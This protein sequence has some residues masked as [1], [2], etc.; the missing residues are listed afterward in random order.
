[1]PDRLRNVTFR[2]P[3]IAGQYKL[4]VPLMLLAL[5]FSGCSRPAAVPSHN[6]QDKNSG[7]KVIV[8]SFYPVYILTQNVCA[9]IPGIMVVNM[10]EPQTG[11]LHDYQLRPEDVK[12]LEKADVF[13]IN[14]A[15]AEAFMDKVIQQQPNLT[16]IEASHGI[17]LIEGA[18]NQGD[19]P[20][21]WVSPALYIKEIE[22]V[23][24]G[25]VQA[26]PAHATQYQS[27]GQAYIK[28][29]KTLQKGMHRELDALKHRNVVTFHEAFP[30]FAQEFKLN[31]VAIIEREPGSAPS[32]AELAQTIETVKKSGTRALFAEPQ[33]SVKA[34]QTIASETG[35]T[36]Y[37]LDP[38]VTG[39]D[40]P[41]AYIKIM[42]QNLRI[43]KEA[44]E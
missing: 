40:Q 8:T 42:T 29:I 39:P 20:H 38:G 23:I 35:A 25:L 11:C 14:G 36:V 4:L 3:W 10:T 41:D 15:G 12:T 9:N 18:G 5:L 27:N 37:S 34:A 24:S 6:G 1:M 33:Y 28:K 19:N 44:L 32:A 26:D 22:N 43:L 17:K 30:Y 21:V 16:I 2:Q 13:V 7:D 31:V